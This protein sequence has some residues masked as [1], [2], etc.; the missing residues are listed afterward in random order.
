MRFLAL[1]DSYT[2]GESVEEH[3]RWPVQLVRLLEAEG[4]HTAELLIVAQTGWTTD[5]LDAGIDAANPQGVYDLVS[6]LI[7]VNNQYRGLSQTRY[8]QEFRA[9]LERAI[10]FAGGETAAVVVLSI[11][12]WSVVPFAEGRDRSQISAEINQFN[13]INQSE[14][15]ACGCHYVNVTPNSRAAASDPRLIAEDGLHPSGD[16]YAQWAHLVSPVAVSILRQRR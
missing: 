15:V 10:Q 12:D 6:L 9:L 4:I 8:R 14:T 16:M 11:P 5:E 3:Q 2:I 7:G 13:N 1:G